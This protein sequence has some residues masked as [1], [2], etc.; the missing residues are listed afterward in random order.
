MNDSATHR[1]SLAPSPLSLTV[2]AVCVS[3]GAG[4][5]EPTPSPDAGNDAAPSDAESDA[6]VLD[7]ASVAVSASID[8]G[9][10]RRL[11]LASNPLR[12][13]LLDADGTTLVSTAPVA[14]EIGVATGGDA[15]YHDVTSPEPSR[16]TWRALEL[17]VASVDASTVR[18]GDG[19]GHVARIELTR[20]DEGALGLRVE[21]EEGEADV[22]LLRLRLASDDG[23]YQGLGER[24]PGADARGHI[25]PMQLSVTSQTRDSGTNEAH[26]PVPFVVSSKRYGV[27]V[28]TREAGAFDV[29]ATDA[30]E[31]RATFE[32]SRLDYV[33]F[34]GST[35]AEVIARYTRHTALP[36]LPPRW[37]FAPQ[38]WRNEWTNREALETDVRALADLHLPATAFWIDN[39]WL[40]SYVDNTF[41]ETRFP[42][43]AEML[44]AL[45]DA[46]FRVLVWNVPYLDAPDDGVAD[47]TAE[48]LFQRAESEGLLVRTAS[49]SLF[50]APSAS[51]VYGLDAAGGLVDFTQDEAVAFWREGVDPLVRDLGIRAFKLDYGEDVIPELLGVRAG[52]A[53]GDGTTERTTHNRFAQ[54]Y[55]TPYRQALDAH[56]DEGGFLLVRASCW[57]GQ[58]TADIIWP[59]DIDATLERGTEDVVGGLPSAISA[60]VSLAA[61]GFPSF[62]SDTGGYRHGPPDLETLLRWAEHTAFAPFLQLGG[63]GPH[64]NPWLYEP[65]AAVPD[66]T[67]TYRELART[68]MELVPFFR[69]LATRAATDGT[70]PVL[71]PAL[72]FPDDAAG[73]ADPDVY[74][75][76]GDLLVAPVVTPGATTRTLHLPAGRWVHWW[77]GTAYDGPVD[78]TVDAPIGAPPAFV[79]AGAIVPMLAHDLETLVPSPTPYAG[80][81]ARIDPAMRPFLRAMSTPSGLASVRVEEGVAITIDHRTGLSIDVVPAT[82]LSDWSGPDLGLRTVHLELNLASAQPAITAV[83]AVRIDAVDATARPA[84]EVEGG[85]CSNCWAFDGSR[86]LVSVDAS[87]AAHVEVQ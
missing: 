27:F 40:V 35:P 15:R 76:G 9:A 34:A 80:T 16:V 10:G 73:F 20:V 84:S 28:E 61:S 29:A 72:A 4:C 68:H 26:V 37:A 77:T 2:V 49:G 63:G 59:G 14:L 52:L 21:L 67:S 13:E 70:P 38:H 60:L 65:T 78:V 36:L 55:H 42:S 85:T 11:T 46:G 5:G 18:V 31:V 74:V 22:A 19:L 12:I 82:E 79:R 32:G 53:F 41:D 48:E 66:P 6:A 30:S 8:D 44:A 23:S 25:V 45:R 57:G 17:G 87:D 50:Y 83:S 39:P 33:F 81:T 58:A 7:A 1:A 24:F 71:H 69:L 47:N 54:R 75:L 51:G 43:S 56:S 64:H 62:A 86:L 3:L